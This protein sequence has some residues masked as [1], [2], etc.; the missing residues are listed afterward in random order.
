MYQ[1]AGS[2]QTRVVSPHLAREA[3]AMPNELRPYDGLRSVCGRQWG[4]IT[5]AQIRAAGYSD[6]EIDGMVRRGLLIRMHRGVYVLG[7]L[8]PAP[9]QR[10]AA[11][12]LAAGKGAA[13]MHTA[14]AGNYGLLPPR[15][16]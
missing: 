3:E 8:S 7:A 16:V 12:L 9:E 4:A 15:E 5:R 1:R 13:L 6:D 2:L 10:L 14:A 11:A